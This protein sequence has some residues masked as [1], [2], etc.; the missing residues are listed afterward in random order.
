MGGLLGFIK[1]AWRG[2]ERLWK[3]WWLFGVFINVSGLLFGW[4]LVRVSQLIVI[5]LNLNFDSFLESHLF[6]SLLLSVVG[7]LL[8]CA[9]LYYYL[10]W[11]GMAWAC[12][13][14]ARNRS[15]GYVAK[16]CVI[17]SII[18]FSLE[19]CGYTMK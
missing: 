16:G 5:K 11:W 14:N 8:G 3:V 15:W 6:I 1:R 2:E 18:K 19:V 9:I 4:L 13:H 7:I 17:L 10:T 12:A